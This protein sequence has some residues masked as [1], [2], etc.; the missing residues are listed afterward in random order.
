MLWFQ[1]F[2]AAPPLVQ[3]CLESWRRHN[4]GWRILALD[5]TSLTEWIDLKQAIDPERSDLDMRKL[6]NARGFACSAGM[7][8]SGPTRPRSACARSTIGLTRPTPPASS[9]SAIR[10]RTA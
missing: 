3:A 2:A 8:V 1:G 5:R 9:P 6:A 7:A 4:P 10:R